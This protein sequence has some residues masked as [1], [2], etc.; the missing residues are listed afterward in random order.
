MLV[1]FEVKKIKEIINDC[2]AY[3]DKKNHMPPSFNLTPREFVIVQ[4]ARKEGIRLTV[5]YNGET[6]PIPLTK[7]Y[8]I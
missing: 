6:R 1:E 7:R 3:V 4:K 5:K 2:Q 8:I